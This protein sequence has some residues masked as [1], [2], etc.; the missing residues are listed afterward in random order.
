MNI[1][2]CGAGEV[3]RQTSE[4]LA[5][6]GHNVTVIDLDAL[7]LEA[8]DE[9]L[10]VRSL[11]GNGTQADVLLEAGCATADLFI[12][13]TSLDEINLL[14][15]SVAKGVGAGKCIARVHHSAYFDQRGLSYTSHLGIDHLVCPEYSTALAIASTLRAPGAI[16]VEQFARGK[17]EMQHLP[18]SPKASAAGKKLSDLRF[19]APA[20]VASVERAGKAML[21]SG[22]TVIEPEDLVTLIGDSSSFDKVRKLFQTQSE[23]R[24]RVMVLGGTTQGVWLSRALRHRNFSVRL[25]EPNAERA[26]ELSE[27]LGW[28]T[29]LNADVMN[30]DTL[31][32]ERVDQVDAFVACTTDDETNILV[33]AQAKSMGAKHGI[34]VLQRSA[35]LHLLQHVGIDKAFSPGRTAVGE[36]QRRL[37]S[38]PVRHLATLAGDVAEVFEIRVPATATKL[39]DSPLRQVHFPHQTTVAVIQRGDDVFVPGAESEIHVGDVVIVISPADNRKDLRRLFGGRPT[40]DSAAKVGGWWR[41]K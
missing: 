34:V 17:V 5:G 28:V 10:D 7:K 11:R 31:Q 30:S 35:Y 18:V 8:L 1:V 14:A 27:K 2:I 24:R 26:A 19:P 12:A 40:S 41:S 29:V 39:L 16:A 25:F 13:A 4:V 15:A 33:A 3:G 21:P 20:R 32:E 22:D 38:N 6:A 9:L 37:D 23:Y 36:I